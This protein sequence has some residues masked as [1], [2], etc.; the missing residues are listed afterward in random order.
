MIKEW[1]AVAL[2]G[3]LG[4]LCRHALGTAVRA[5]HPAWLPFATLTVNVVGCFAIGWLVHWTTQRQ[6][7][8]QWWEVGLRVGVLGGLTTFSS[9]ALEAIHAWHHRP[10]LGFSI[11]VAHVTLGLVCVLAGMSVANWTR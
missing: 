9:F 10:W 4:T 1:L 5:V 11:V 8:N 2:G 7:T 3:M 6:W